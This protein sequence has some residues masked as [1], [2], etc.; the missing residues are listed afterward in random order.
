MFIYTFGYTLT[1]EVFT[2][3]FVFGKCIIFVF[4]YTNYVMYSDPSLPLNKDADRCYFHMVATFV[5]VLCMM[6]TPQGEPH[7]VKATFTW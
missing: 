3:V 5:D 6:Q 2:I 4:L 1:K 7:N